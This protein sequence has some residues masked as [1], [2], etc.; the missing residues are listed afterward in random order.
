MDR[1]AALNLPDPG[2]RGRR[3]GKRSRCAPASRQPGRRWR[4]RRQA[5]PQPV[6]VTG[7]DAPQ[8][9]GETFSYYRLVGTAFNPRTSTTT[10]DYNFDGCIY[11]TA[12][13]DNRF[14]APLLVPDGAV[15]KYLRLYYEDSSTT[16]DLTAWI[17][18]YQPGVTSE[19]LD[20]AHFS[21]I[22][23]LRHHAQRGDHPHRQ[24]GD[25]GVHHHRRSQCKCR[26][27]FL[28]RHPRGLL[29]PLL[30]RHGIAGDPEVSRSSALPASPR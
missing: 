12:G 3:W 13:S 7:P 23:R 21:R 24:P 27:K 17:T 20:L 9:P 18:R 5:S 4:R 8:E 30:R 19:D 1:P 16:T 6:A 15:L 25:L 26:N 14:M 10:F 2:S 11:E 28:V 29:R 22:I